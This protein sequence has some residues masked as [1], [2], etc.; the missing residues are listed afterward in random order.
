GDT[1]YIERD[2]VSIYKLNDKGPSSRSGKPGQTGFK[3]A[4][5]L[6]NRRRITPSLGSVQRAR[7]FGSYAQIFNQPCAPPHWGPQKVDSG[8]FL[9]PMAQGI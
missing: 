9:P 6:H 7:N 2:P 4:Y 1:T 8:L 3:V 5:P